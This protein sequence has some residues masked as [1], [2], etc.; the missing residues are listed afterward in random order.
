MAIVKTSKSRIAFSVKAKRD[1]RDEPH[2]EKR[3]YFGCCSR[4]TKRRPEENGQL[5]P[6]RTEE[7]TSKRQEADDQPE[8]K[9][10]TKRAT[11]AADSKEAKNA[12]TLPEKM[13]CLGEGYNDPAHNRLNNKEYE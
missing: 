11:T 8:K 9:Q 2:N 6:T 4:E 10:P 5:Q 7:K 1:R 13:K 3:K 12:N